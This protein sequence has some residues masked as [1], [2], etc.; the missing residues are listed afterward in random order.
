MLFPPKSLIPIYDQL[1]SPFFLHPPGVDE[2]KETEFADLKRLAFAE[3]EKNTWQSVGKA[4]NYA[5]KA[6]LY[7][8]VV[9][10]MLLADVIYQ[11]ALSDQKEDEPFDEDLKRAI[12]LYRLA[13]YCLNNDAEISAEL[14]AKHAQNSGLT[15]AEIEKKVELCLELMRTVKLNEAEYL[16]DTDDTFEAYRSRCDSNSVQ[17]DPI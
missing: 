5:T 8:G 9:G 14:I 2:I 13:I 7:Y 16:A 10:F 12:V 4:I 17:P 6:A 11:N 1:D 3:L 15:K